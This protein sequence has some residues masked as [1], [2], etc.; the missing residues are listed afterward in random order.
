MSRRVRRQRSCPVYPKPTPG[1]PCGKSWINTLAKRFLKGKKKEDRRACE[2]KQWRYHPRPRD[3][4]LPRNPVDP[5]DPTTIDCRLG[6]QHQCDLRE[7]TYQV[8]RACV[9]AEDLWDETDV[10]PGR[11]MLAEHNPSSYS[12]YYKGPI[13]AGPAPPFGH[14]FTSSAWNDRSPTRY[15]LHETITTSK[16]ELKGTSFGE[17]RGTQCCHR[18][19]ACSGGTCRAT[20]LSDAGEHCRHRDRAVESARRMQPSTSAAS[21]PESSARLL[22][23]SPQVTKEPEPSTRKGGRGSVSFRRRRSRSPHQLLQLLP[24]FTAVAGA[25]VCVLLGSTSTGRAAI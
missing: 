6:K 5:A 24:S 2:G 7:T 4:V 11:R 3:L 13:S 9:Y 19:S 18:N 21:A 23:T 12:N 22:E 17:E 25:V 20:F 8:Q 10:S 14:C 16:T 15:F 1:D